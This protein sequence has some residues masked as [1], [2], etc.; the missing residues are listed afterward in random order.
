MGERIKDLAVIKLKD[1]P[2]RIELNRGSAHN[3]R[4]D[5]IHIQNDRL[6]LEFTDSE[7][8]QLAMAVRAAAAKLRK[9]KDL[10]TLAD[11]NE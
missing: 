9:Y 7:Y 6:R 8:L 2:V 4:S 3:S 11:E 10:D 1:M 5:Y